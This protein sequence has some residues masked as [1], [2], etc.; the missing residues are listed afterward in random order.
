MM[1]ETRLSESQ[2]KIQEKKLV[3]MVQVGGDIR[4][5]IALPSLSGSVCAAP[6]AA[7]IRVSLLKT[8]RKAVLAAADGDG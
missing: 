2:K 6:S 8:N 5:Q 1:S 4:V 7:S 3:S